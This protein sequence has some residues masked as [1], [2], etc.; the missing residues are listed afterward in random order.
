L[1]PASS[2]PSGRKKREAAMVEIDARRQK[3]KDDFIAARR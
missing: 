1:P 3:L 2:R